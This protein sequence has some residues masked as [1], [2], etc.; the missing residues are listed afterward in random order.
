MRDFENIKSILLPSVSTLWDIT[1]SSRFA[2]VPLRSSVYRV[3]HNE[4]GRTV[5]AKKLALRR[6]QTEQQALRRWLPFLGIQ[7]IGCTLLAVTPD[8]SGSAIWHLYEDYGDW[9]LDAPHV[10]EQEYRTAAFSLGR[11][12]REA[13]NRSI[14]AEVR[15]D[16]RDLSSSFYRTSV[17][18]AL[19]GIAELRCALP[20]N[21]PR[22]AVLDVLTQRMLKMQLE[23]PERADLL[24]RFG[25]PETFLH[26][27]LNLDN[28]FAT[29][30]GV[31][32]QVRFIDWDHAGSGPAVYDL[33]NFLGAVPP[34]KRNIVAQAY[35]SA[36]T[37]TAWLPESADLANRLFE[38]A[39]LARLANRVVWICSAALDGEL[40]WGLEEL[41]T[42]EGWFQQL[43]PLLEAA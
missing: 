12:H 38:T 19:R 6:A 28:V 20:G 17:E 32:C 35:R 27:D 18:D 33:S 37:G 11:L 4:T 10:G 14:L 30:S 40:N 22:T 1:T 29:P 5:I 23:F 36:F 2:V 7:D 39:E 31:G 21:S 15:L 34:A 3:R 24:V 26:G 42:V 13:A 9:R 8:P 43:K 41:D 25:G 16:G